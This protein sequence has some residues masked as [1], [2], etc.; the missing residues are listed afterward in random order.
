MS[1]LLALSLLLAVPARAAMVERV[2]LAPALG[3]VE[4]APAFKVSV[5]NQVQLANSLIAAPT[6]TLAPMLSAAPTAADP[7]R[8]ESAKLVGA[9]IARPAAVAAHQQELR[10]ALG[11]QG[12]D[13][14]LKVSSRVQARAAEH[15]ELAAQLAQ[16]KGGVDIENGA[17]VQEMGARLNALFENSRYRPEAPD[18]V[19]AGHASGTHKPVVGLARSGERPT[20]TEQELEAYVNERSITSPRGLRRVNFA[21]GDYRPEYD[22]ALRRMGVDVAVIKAPSR[23]ELGKYKEEDGYH[24][25]SE[26]ERWVL[27]VRTPEEHEAMLDHKRARQFRKEMAASEHLPEIGRASCRERVLRLV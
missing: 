13:N 21:S 4:S 1:R 20:M 9:L 17:S 26:Y 18:A 23:A 10:A 27:T 7:W 5:L 3:M 11:D 16:L 15:P 2:S 14:L 6:P 8:A 12:V 25:K 24:L 22:A 19:A